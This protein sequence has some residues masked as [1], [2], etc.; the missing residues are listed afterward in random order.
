MLVEI[1]RR[2]YFA[3]CLSSNNSGNRLLAQLKIVQAMVFVVS[4]VAT[5]SKHFMCHFSCCDG[6]LLSS[7]LSEY[8]TASKVAFFLINR[9]YINWYDNE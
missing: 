4:N 3:D 9:A 6:I 1:S 5:L 8:R 2:V 7:L